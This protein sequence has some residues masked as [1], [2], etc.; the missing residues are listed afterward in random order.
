MWV[1]AQREDS[2][3]GTEWGLTLRDLEDHQ[4]CP[5][6]T[7]ERCGHS[8]NEKAVGI[9]HRIILPLVRDQTGID[10]FKHSRNPE[11]HSD[12]AHPM[13]RRR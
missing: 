13:G 10:A 12:A 6:H 2:E 3:S 4:G 8:A 1:P 11:S 5:R 7:E 9:L